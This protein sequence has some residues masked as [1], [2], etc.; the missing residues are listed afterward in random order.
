MTPDFLEIPMLG[1]TI[2]IVRTPGGVLRVVS[3]SG[4]KDSTA[5]Y[6]WA[7][8]Q[9]GKD[10]F[11]AIFADTG[12]ENKV[13]I[14]YL[15]NLPD[16][17]GGP[18]IITV[19]ADFRDRLKARFA[20]LREAV[21]GFAS[22]PMPCFAEGYVDRC[23]QKMAEIE[24][25]GYTT[26]SAFLDLIIWK[27]RVPSTKAQFCTDFLKIRPIHEWIE[28]HRGDLAIENYVGIRAGESAKRALMTE[29]DHDKRLDADVFRPLLKWSEQQVFDYLDERGVEPNPLYAAGFTRVGCFP[30]I[31]A[32]KAE[33][34]RL[35]EETWEKLTDW[36][37]ILGQSWFPP[38]L[39]PI[40]VEDQ[41]KL[42]DL[43][44]RIKWNKDPCQ[45]HGDDCDDNW[46]P[47]ETPE[48]MAAF[49]AHQI[50]WLTAVIPTVEQAREWATT[51]RG[52][53]SARAFSTR[54]RRRA[55]LHEHMGGLR[56]SEEFCAHLAIY[57]L[58][59]AGIGSTIVS[60]I[61][62]RRGLRGP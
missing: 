47:V 40:G 17:A 50:F 33:L 21:R 5:L 59:I 28:A 60:L 18:E 25:N 42:R 14:N 58:W 38:G 31:H 53:A 34:A 9:W 43:S 24:A 27:G 35:P 55:E 3:V 39:I 49:H 62:F 37:Q 1:G 45:E 20:I 36:Q 51:S 44:S 4:G 48:N 19:R 30:C 13:T 29:C 22:I 46:T 15:R 61:A 11:I 26:G 32:R 10:G 52:G 7:I 23:L 56:V 41:L 8:E 6:L 54:C 2:Q 16:M 57:V 12:H